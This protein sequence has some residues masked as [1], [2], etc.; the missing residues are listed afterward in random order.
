[1]KGEENRGGAAHEEGMVGFHGKEAMAAEPW[2]GFGFRPPEYWQ[3]YAPD[4]NGASPDAYQRGLTV[5]EIVWH[6][7]AV[8]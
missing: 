5:S 2:I 8:V 4:F 6:P 7:R 1:M 3:F